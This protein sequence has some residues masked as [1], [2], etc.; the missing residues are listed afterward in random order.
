MPRLVPDV[1]LS[2]PYNSVLIDCHR[3]LGN[4]LLPLLSGAA[5]AKERGLP[6]FFCWNRYQPPY[7]TPP[8]PDPIYSFGLSLEDLWTY[9]EQWRQIVPEEM[10]WRKRH[11]RRALY[12]AGPAMF[13]AQAF[14]MLSCLSPTS[15]V[16]ER[17]RRMSEL[18]LAET[19]AG[20]RPLVSV[21][22]RTAC[23][24]GKVTL[25]QSPPSWFEDRMR[26]IEQDHPKVVFFLSSESEELCRSWSSMFKSPVL[27]Q[28]RKNVKYSTPEAISIAAADLH[29]MATF[30]NHLLAPSGS[31]FWRIA[32]GLASVDGRNITYDTAE[33]QCSPARRR[34]SLTR[35]ENPGFWSVPIDAARSL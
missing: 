12:Y 35:R 11:S 14:S 29:L 19:D 22:V 34:F 32:V 31:T 17:V 13:H 25:R 5:F 10:R 30:S 24:W 2:K 26:Q 33:D 1:D 4:R 8:W 16:C 21:S 3:G 27:W 15:S 23:A 6:L 20:R 28:S 9:P 18:L 7:S